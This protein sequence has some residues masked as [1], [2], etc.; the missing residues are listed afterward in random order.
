MSDEHK[1]TCAACN[2]VVIKDFP[3]YPPGAANL[4]MEC[5][6]LLKRFDEYEREAVRDNDTIEQ[7]R[8]RVAELEALHSPNC[9]ILDRSPEGITKPCN[10]QG[11][12]LML[13]R[14]NIQKLE[15]QLAEARRQF[16]LCVENLRRE[17]QLACDLRSTQDVVIERCAKAVEDI[18]PESA[19][20]LLRHCGGLQD[21]NVAVSG[22]DFG[23]LRR[24][25]ACLTAQLAEAQKRA[26]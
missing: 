25:N 16:E 4:A 21:S 9:D 5:E 19:A 14:G 22:E 24:E 1:V 8:K 12:L 15:E 11:A 23:E 6:R 7:L 20:R 18:S 2:G 17:S 3:A 10:C 13:L 26:K